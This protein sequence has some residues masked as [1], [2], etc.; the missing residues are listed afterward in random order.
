MSFGFGVG[1][2]LAVGK[3]AL[4]LYNACA[5]APAE[6]EELKKDLSSIHTVISGLQAQAEDRQSLLRQRCVDRKPE[7]VRLRDNLLET[8]LEL[9]DLITKYKE[10]GKNAFMR[11]RLGIQKL[12][13]LRGKLSLHL[14]A[15]NT[16][17][18]SLSLSAL[19]RMEPVLGRIECLLVEFVREERRGQR[20]RTILSAHDEG[21]GQSWKQMKLD[22]MLEGI[23]REDFERNEE[24]IKEILDWVINDG[25]DLESL[26][27]VDVD[28]SISQQGNL[29]PQRTSKKMDSKEAG[30]NPLMA[31]NREMEKEQEKDRASKIPKAEI[32]LQKILDSQIS[33]N[34]A[35]SPSVDIN[36]LIVDEGLTR[37]SFTMSS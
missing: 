16:F 19:G 5:D 37:T 8:L 20:P 35:H 36:I 31:F 17:V 2:F 30:R 4:T 32:K 29:E 26:A 10:M 15:I 23:S 11:I 34:Y 22:F 33:R 12:N 21:G 1:D 25:R 24:R 7:W 14:T 3:L 27:E 18:A 28:D 13:D 6:F 9:Q